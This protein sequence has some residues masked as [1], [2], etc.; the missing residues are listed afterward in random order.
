[1]SDDQAVKLGATEGRYRERRQAL[2]R[3]QRDLRMALDDQ[4]RPGVPAIADSV[5]K[6]MDALQAGRAELLKLEQDEDREM[7]SYLTPVQ[8]AQY[9]TLRLRFV[10]RVQDLR[11]GR[12]GLDRPRRRPPARRPGRMRD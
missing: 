8:R 7:A 10:Q 1:L 6:L 5:R 12:G 2:T 11:R 9:Q 4:M 3:H